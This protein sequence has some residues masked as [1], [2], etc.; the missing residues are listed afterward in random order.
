MRKPGTAMESTENEAKALF[1]KGI[2]CER[3]GNP[4]EATQCYK[5][6]L[7]LDPDVEKK[8]AHED[9][10]ARPMDTLND[11]NDESEDE[12]D[13]KEDLFLRFQRIM[14]PQICFP[15][16]EQRATHFS[17][18]P[19]ELILYIFRWVV[20]N[21]LDLRTLEQCSAVC[22]GWYLCARDPELW[23]R[24]CL[25]FWPSSSDDLAPF[26]GS[27]RR[28]FIERPNVLTIGCYICKVSYVRQGEES[29]RDNSNG[30]SFNVVY[31]RYLRFFS[32][33]RVLMLLSYHPPAKIVRKLQTNE[34]A[35][36]NVCPGHYRLS[37]NKLYLTLDSEGE[38]CRRT[39]NKYVFC[40]ENSERK[41]TYNMILE[42]SKYRSKHNWKLQCIDY[43]IVYR[44]K[45]NEVMVTKYVLSNNRFPPFIFS[46]VKCFANESVH[47]L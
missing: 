46:R 29:F 14:G 34:T 16:H 27:W 7:K 20:S 11:Q 32:D 43:E 22:R 13:N 45:N 12:Y 35:P 5:R 1:R 17:V 8:I 42:I 40:N 23:R 30:P 44:N 9:A 6:A 47:V 31:Y 37:G 36:F 41:T 15:E 2:E 21:D 10:I 24:A 38:E 28:M 39:R 19:P 33:G 26:D 4:Y 3:D 25:K 18:L